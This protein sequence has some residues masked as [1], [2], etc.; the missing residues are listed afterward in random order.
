MSRPIDKLVA[1]LI[2][3]VGAAEELVERGRRA[4]DTDRIL[5]LA[6]EAVVGR[7]GDAAAKLRDLVGEELPE[8][9]PWDDVIANRII[10]DHVYQ[11][12]DY[13]LLWNTLERDVPALGAALRD[14]ARGR[15][16]V[17]DQSDSTPGS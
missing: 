11:R 16:V 12:V 15:G 13:Q 5:R 14:W 8:E 3:A 9:V 10:V 2:D 1:D 6:G 4:H 7:I 17:L